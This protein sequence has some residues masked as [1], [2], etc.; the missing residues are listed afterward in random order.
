VIITKITKDTNNLIFYTEYLSAGGKAY[1]HVGACPREAFV[2][3]VAL[4][5][6]GRLSGEGKC[7]D[8]SNLALV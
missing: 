7:A 5:R 4:P 3:G 8:V 2:G 1:I 6:E